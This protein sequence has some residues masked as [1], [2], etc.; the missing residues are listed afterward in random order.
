M[1]P[2]KKKHFVL[3]MVDV[4]CFKNIND[5]FG[6][7]TGDEVRKFIAQVLM[8]TLRKND[9]V[10]RFGGDEFIAVFQDVDAGDV[11]K[12]F[13]RVSQNIR[14]T[15]PFGFAISIAYGVEAVVSLDTIDDA[16][17]KADEKMYAHKK[18]CQFMYGLPEA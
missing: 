1:R 6:H 15:N 9:F 7:R 13:D 3:A 17:K 5:N 2:E 11:Y 16:V 10:I 14:D 18:E 12:I 8:N 4:N